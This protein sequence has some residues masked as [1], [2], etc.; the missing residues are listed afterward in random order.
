MKKRSS[1]ISF[2]VRIVASALVTSFLLS[3]T[4]SA[5]A[6]SD[7]NPTVLVNTT[8]HNTIDEGNGTS[9]IELRFGQTLNE[10]LFFD[11]ANTRFVFTKGLLINGNTKVIGNLSGSTLNVDGTATVN[12]AATINGSVTTNG[13][14]TNNG[15]VTNASTTTLNGSVTTNGTVTNNGAVTNASTTTLNGITTINGAVTHANTTTLNGVTTANANVK[16]RGNLSGSTLN[17]DGTSALKGTLSVTDSISTNN[18]VT[19]NGDNDSNNAV[20]TF[21]NQAAS[22]VLQFSNANQ[23]FEFSKDVKVTGNVRTT[24]NLSGSTLTVDGNITM[25][26]ITYAAPTA[27]GGTNTFLKND[28][29]GN[30]IWANTAVSTSSGGELSLHPQYPNAIYA[31]SGSTAV[32]TLTQGA[33]TTNKEL[34]YRWVGDDPTA[35]QDY[36]VWVRVKVPK[37]F[38]NWTPAP[39]QFRYRTSSTSAAVNYMNV[40]LLDTTGANVAVTGGTGLVSGTANT[41]QTATLGN[42]SGGTFTPDGYVTVLIKMAS[43]NAGFADAGYLNFNWSTTT[44]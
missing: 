21:G 42:L 43:T 28:G 9:N 36:W 3:T 33:D 38:S 8:S 4:G 23:R 6:A 41:W 40:R 2:R 44:P 35:I 1:L 22:Q 19:I 30:L 17:V 37:N 16:V 27:Q 11:R 34:Y 7:W 39:I 25:R 24:G 29:A 10:K 14:V 15:A 20:L 31:Q 5:Y 26:G 32:G 13:T 18:N 12:G